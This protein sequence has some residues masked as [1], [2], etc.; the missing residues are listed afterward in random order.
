MS[1]QSHSLLNIQFSHPAC[2]SDI[3]VHLVPKEEKEK[4]LPPSNKGIVPAIKNLSH[5]LLCM[6]G[7]SMKRRLVKAALSVFKAPLWV[8]WVW[9]TL[10][11]GLIHV[12]VGVM[13]WQADRLTCRAGLSCRRSWRSRSRR[14]RKGMVP[15]WQPTGGA[16]ARTDSPTAP[17][18]NQ[19][20]RSPAAG[21]PDR[22]HPSIKEGLSY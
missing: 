8:C 7:D 17:E 11:Y 6:V 20:I 12:M 14:R 1:T 16:A 13:M 21:Q 2:P 15:W 5:S 3:W 10:I 18:Q 4:E 19:L 9:E 22:T